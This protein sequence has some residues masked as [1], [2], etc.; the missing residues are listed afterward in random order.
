MSVRVQNTP[1][2]L[3][4]LLLAGILMVVVTILLRVFGLLDRA[5][6][7]LGIVG[8]GTLVTHVSVFLVTVFVLAAVVIIGIAAYS[9]IEEE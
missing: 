9:T 7:K 4:T 8:V 3:V 1:V 5:F 2:V 6:S